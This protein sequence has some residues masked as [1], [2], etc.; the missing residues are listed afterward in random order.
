M[1]SAGIPANASEPLEFFIDAQD[2]TL[3]FYVY[4]HFTE[5]VKLEANQ[6]RHFNIS[7]N[8]KYWSDLTPSYLYTTKVF[9]PSALTGGKHTFSIF[10]SR[11]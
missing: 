6:S 5:I 1:N 11:G 8:G 4:M 7:L 2:T 3:K 9:S 10:K